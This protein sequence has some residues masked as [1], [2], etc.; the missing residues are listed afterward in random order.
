MIFK[1]L[2]CCLPGKPPCLPNMLQ[3]LPASLERSSPLSVESRNW[4][5]ARALQ[6][7]AQRP[8]DEAKW[9]MG[10]EVLS[11]SPPMVEDG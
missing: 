8:E 2:A 1:P 10:G 4:V 11:F 5:Q 3:Y 6:E 7:A 9:Q